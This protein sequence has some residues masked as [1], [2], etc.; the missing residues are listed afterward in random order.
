MPGNPAAPDP[1]DTNIAD[2][3]G[4]HEPVLPG[5]E[6]F[7]GAEPKHALYKKQTQQGASPSEDSG[8]Q[9]QNVPQPEPGTTSRLL[10]P[11]PKRMSLDALFSR[12]IAALQPYM[13]QEFEKLSPTDKWKTLPDL[14]KEALLYLL[15]T[16]DFDGKNGTKAKKYIEQ[17]QLSNMELEGLKFVLYQRLGD[18][19]KR[20]QALNNLIREA[21][22]HQKFKLENGRFCKKVLS[23]RQ[24]IDVPSVSN[25]PVFHPGAEVTVYCE[26]S[27]AKFRSIPGGKREQQLQAYLSVLDSQKQVIDTILFLN[28][29]NGRRLLQPNE[30]F[31]SESYLTGSYRLPAFLR[32]GI[33]NLRIE[34][35]DMVGEETDQVLL[36]FRV[37]TGKAGG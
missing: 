12:S 18:Y 6:E 2:I 15:L 25:I 3:F 8:F 10:Q 4:E 37:E 30:R 24:Y 32:P 34:T 14:Q 31:H 7:P 11:T 36:S 19:R 22:R 26:F 16:E 35:T 17:I 28:P 20:N 1:A 5:E 9:M 29:E 33:Y 13:E 23:Y 27:G 21:N